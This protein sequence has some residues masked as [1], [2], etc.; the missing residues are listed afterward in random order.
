M[1]PEKVR[2]MR[3]NRKN[4]SVNPN[5]MPCTPW[6]TGGCG[7]GSTCAVALPIQ[8]HLQLRLSTVPRVLHIHPVDCH[9]GMGWNALCVLWQAAFAAGLG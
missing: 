1:V 9:K 7:K 6:V 3:V 2:Q 5:G 8:E 4:C